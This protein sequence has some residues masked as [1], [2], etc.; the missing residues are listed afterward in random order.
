MCQGIQGRQQVLPHALTPRVWG[1]T[2][3]N[4][5]LTAWTPHPLHCRG[6]KKIHSFSS[7][8]PSNFWGATRKSCLKRA[9][10]PRPQSQLQASDSQQFLSPETELSAPC[11]PRWGAPGTG[12]G[13]A[14]KEKSN[15]KY[16][17]SWSVGLDFQV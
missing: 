17:S 16:R 4:P 15:E 3:Q 2:K 11:Q 6:E 13:E 7:L 12:T 1:E 5:L 14:R 9:A 8:V 10:H